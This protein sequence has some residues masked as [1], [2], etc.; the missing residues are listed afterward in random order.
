MATKKKDEMRLYITPEHNKLREIYQV[1][2]RFNYVLM[3]VIQNFGAYMT[4]IWEP[5]E[6][7]I[8]NCVPKNLEKTIKKRFSG[9]EVQIAA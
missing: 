4:I 7:P 8:V 2:P 3:G 6:L 5:K 9:V 1:S